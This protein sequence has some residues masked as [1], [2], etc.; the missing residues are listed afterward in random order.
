MAPE[1]AEVVALDE[2]V[3][4]LGNLA[5]D[6]F[7]SGL[8][9]LTSVCC[10][11]QASLSAVPRHRSGKEAEGSPV[12]NAREP[13]REVKELMASVAMATTDDSGVHG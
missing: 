9:F 12:A 4:L 7:P 10:A 2:Q 1:I 3:G 13:T 5:D 11:C 6:L 8:A